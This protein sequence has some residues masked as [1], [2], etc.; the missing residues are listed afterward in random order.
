MQYLVL[1]TSKSHVIVMYDFADNVNK[2][3]HGCCRIQYSL[4]LFVNLTMFPLFYVSNPVQEKWACL[5]L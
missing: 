3:D 2:I 5:S 4:G 1:Q